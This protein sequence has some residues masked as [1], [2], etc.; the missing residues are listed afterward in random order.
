MQI[1]FS[2]GHGI[3]KKLIWLKNVKV[4]YMEMSS[5]III[6]KPQRL[7]NGEKLIK[8][9]FSGQLTRIIIWI[10]SYKFFLSVTLYVCENT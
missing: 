7:K 5:N 9:H 10:L 2:E 4:S 3:I 8:M 6:R 1:T